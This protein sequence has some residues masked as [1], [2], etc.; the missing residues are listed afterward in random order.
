VLL[1]HPH[2]NT[3][4]CPDADMAFGATWPAVVLVPLVSAFVP[5]IDPSLVRKPEISDFDSVSSSVVLSLS[6]Q[7][8]N[9]SSHEGRGMNFDDQTNS[10]DKYTVARAGG[11]RPRTD[12]RSK[13]P[14]RNRFFQLIR[15]FALPLCLLTVILR[16]LL[17]MFGGSAGDTGV[18]YYSHSV[19]QST[20]YTKDGNIERTMRENFQSNIPGL[21]GQAKEYKQ[22]KNF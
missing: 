17:S 13:K 8:E 2:A 5:H 1:Q 20:S 16:F 7:A 9:H 19:Y 12:A 22:D 3:R 6:N 18:V 15:D 11:R 21:V 14:D 10:T 4:Q